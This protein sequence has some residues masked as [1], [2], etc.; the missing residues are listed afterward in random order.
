MAVAAHDETKA[1]AFEERMADMLNL[2]GLALMT[3]V[4][5]RTR[6]F[7]TMEAMAPATSGKIAQAAGLNERYV[8]EWLGAMVVG[9]VVE[10]DPADSTYVLPP[11]HAAC[12]TRAAAPNNLAAFAQYVGLLGSV[13]DLVVDCFRNG[14]GVPYSAFTR[15]QEV[16]EDDSSQSVLPALLEHIVPL[17]DGLHQRL[18]RGIDVLDLG[19]G[20]GRA[21]N[22]LARAYPNSRFVGYEISEE[23][24]AAGRAEAAKQ[25]CTNIRF[26]LQDAATMSDTSDF[27]LVCTFDAIHDQADPKRVL[28]NIRAALRPGG[29]YLM[30]DIKGS[31]HVHNNIGHPLGA[32]LYTVSC[33]HCM[34]VS[35]AEGGAGLGTMWGTETALEM[36]RDAGF[37][38]VRMEEL[39]HDVQNAYFVCRP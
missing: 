22:L 28:A 30:Q 1:A 17:V 11:E 8:R 37:G 16:M 23:G 31:R 24:I 14:G 13:E 20:K 35:L 7:D 21:L 27:D 26:A 2:G 33:M 38:D 9:G 25:R 36:L 4:G 12:L 18:Q 15:F 39:E 10:H 6:L 3:S 19:C 29:V 32:M 5:H 34:T